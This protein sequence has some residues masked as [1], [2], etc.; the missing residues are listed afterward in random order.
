MDIRHRKLP[1]WVWFG[2]YRLRTGTS[3]P[4]GKTDLNN[5]KPDIAT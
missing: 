2:L 3:V 4:E 5:A 1:L